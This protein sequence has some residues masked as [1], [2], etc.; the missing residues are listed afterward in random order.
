LVHFD[1]IFA[2]TPA[3][4]WSDSTIYTLRA[5]YGYF[6]KFLKDHHPNL[7]ERA[8]DPHIT[9]EVVDE[10]V[11]YMKMWLRDTSVSTYLQRI[12]IV[13]THIFPDQDFRW[14]S[15]R[16][17]AIG[18][19]AQR[20]RPAIAPTPDLY[21]IGADLVRRSCLELRVAALA[22]TA[23]ERFRDGL[24]IMLLVEAPIRRGALAKIN[25][26]DSFTWNGKQFR[27]SIPRS[28]MKGK[29]RKSSFV[30]SEYLSQCIIAY[31]DY[32]RVQFVGA[33]LHNGF[34]PVDS[35]PMSDAMIYKRV[36]TWTKRYLGY[37]VSPHRFRHSAATFAA[38]SDPENVL[39][40][41]DLLGHKTFATTDDYYVTAARTRVASRR[42]PAII[43][44]LKE[45]ATRAS[46]GGSV[47][48]NLN[49]TA[50]LDSVAAW[51]VSA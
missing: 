8:G 18:H 34:W 47:R 5:A 31:L 46:N 49:V 20:L 15:L 28:N 21:K 4:G 10:F 39:A 25:T 41:R 37:S 6:L 43:A 14:L 12:Y 13:A 48:R 11:A 7:L 35:R 44:K 40:I 9:S 2:D 32:V 22:F 38:Q 24:I 29:R 16:A 51:T 36:T 33:D 50:N 1:D 3:T 30:L 17:R 45:R 42:V 27:L 19:S 23:A 26:E